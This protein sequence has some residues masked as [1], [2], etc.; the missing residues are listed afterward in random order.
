M[1]KVGLIQQPAPNLNR[2]KPAPFVTFNTES[3]QILTPMPGPPRTSLP[4]NKTIWTYWHQGVDP[5]PELVQ[6]CWI[7]WQ[8]CN[9]EY[10]FVALDQ[11]SLH[12]YVDLHERVDLTRRDITVQKIAAMARLLLLVKYGGVWVDATVFAVKPLAEWLPKYYGSG[13][14]AFRYPHPGWM[15]SN[16]LIISEKD[17]VLV[18]ALAETFLQYYIQNRFTNQD[19]RVFK[20]LMTRLVRRLNTP[21][22]SL[23]WHT[24]FARKVLRIYPY[25]IFHYTFNKVV[26]TNPECR[27]TWD[28]AEPYSADDPHFAMR[29]YYRKRPLQEALAYIHSGASPVHKLDWRWQRSDPYQNAILTEFY[30]L[31]VEKKMN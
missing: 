27:K 2:R 30:G 16:W 28:A 31:N 11:H 19:S 13:F 21:E 12:R 3:F 7:S 20:Y 8:R 4:S 26:L 23:F 25:F 1:S 17:N 24:W 22:K 6:Q 9:P 15:L 14:F 10:R 29:C 18:N 5:A